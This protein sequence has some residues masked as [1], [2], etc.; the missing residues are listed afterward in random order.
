M[1]RIDFQQSI[2]Q[3]SDNSNFKIREFPV[4][5][6]GEFRQC[7]ELL[8][9]AILKT[10]RT[11]K[12]LEWIPE[13]DEI[14]NWMV[15]TKGKGLLLAGDVGRGKTSII[16]HALPLLFFSSLNKIVKCT[17]ANELNSH[18]E[19]YKPK[20]LIAVDDMGTE[21]IINHFGQKYE[22]M[23]RLFD[24]AESKSKTLFISTNLS[25]TEIQERYG[26]RTIDRISRLCKI[27]K[28]SGDSFR[29]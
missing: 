29:N 22:P 9:Q 26:T 6:F 15:D 3:L 23:N 12:N 2:A 24:M 8:T 5:R 17:H 16:C 13:Y 1:K 19:E 7:K 21:T 27:V 25:S 20:L 10:D 14:A 4:F 11:I 28:F 18:L